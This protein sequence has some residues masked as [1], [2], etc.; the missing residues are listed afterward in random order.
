MNSP[1]QG[2][3]VLWCLVAATSAYAALGVLGRLTM[4]S[5]E[6]LAL[7]WPAAGGAVLLVGVLPRS[8][9]PAG[10]AALAAATFLVNLG[11]GAAPSSAAA[12]VVPNVV[13]GLVGA[14]LLHRVV[15]HLVL[16]GG[17]AALQTL[18]D[19]V[20]LIAAA[21]VSSVAAVSVG[22]LV[23]VL[24]GQ[25][26]W[27]SVGSVSWA[28]RNAVG[29]LVVLTL[30]ALL[31]GRPEE[32]PPASR[33]SGESTSGRG[34]ELAALVV[35]TTVLYLVVFTGVAGV[36][37][38]FPLLV[39]TVWAGLRFGLRIVT[40]HSLVIAAA[41]VVAT[42]QRQGPFAAVAS[43]HEKALLAQCFM[44]MVLVVGILLA[45]ASEERRLLA[46]TLR[47]AHDEASNQAALLSTV[48]DSMREGIT[49]VDAEGRVLL[50]NPAGDD[51]LRRRTDDRHQVDATVVDVC[52]STGR[53][54]PVEEWPFSRALRGEEIVGADLTLSF[55]EHLPERDLAVSARRL[56]FPSPDG[57]PQAVVIYH[58]VTS[59]RAQ[60]Q[61]LESFARTVA[62]DL[63]GPLGVVEGWGELLAGDARQ[64]S[65]LTAGDVAGPA[66][67][68]LDATAT[69]RHLV[70][71]LLERSLSRDQQPRLEPLDLAGLTDEVAQQHR[72]TTGAPPRITVGHVPPVLGDRAMLR[73]VLHNLLGN[74]VKY[75]APGEVA[76][77][78][79]TGSTLPTSRGPV[80]EVVVADRGI[81]IPEG[82]HDRVFDVFGRAHAGAAYEGQGIGL[83]VCRTVLQRH[84][85]TIVARP[86][87]DGP[88]TAFVLTLP[89]VPA[90]Q[91]GPGE[92]RPRRV[93]GGLA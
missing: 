1:S 47:R 11:A 77:I 88:G 6:P 92:Q 12:F 9:W 51:L 26:A 13:Q 68:I 30:A 76:D 24:L 58:D 70:S 56:P 33:L 74:A 31:L 75:V 86:R 83:S 27:S 59:E 48:I 22:T 40:V 85:G 19:Y 37:L 73:Q 55:G 39:P 65:V 87:E 57:R 45:L 49:L 46:R 54:L 72:S 66:G 71:D 42:L 53:R 14:A 35:T 78:A 17:R 20:A 32:R 36:P 8:W 15:P 18:R 23:M 10:L 4:M 16:G 93:V 5:G 28:G 90:A 50:Q 89:A 81:G 21:A 82:E 52:D 67:R 60:R 7:V 84:A 2:V 61:A 34:V 69:M 29:A 64:R 80:V 3:R 62:H 91:A 25:M 63:K 44:G 38:A 79:V 43:G 41:V